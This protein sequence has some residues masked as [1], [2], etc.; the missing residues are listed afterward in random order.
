MAKN[1]LTAIG[2]EVPTNGAVATIEACQP[3][4][5]HVRIVGTAD[6]LFHR[7][8]C[9]DVKA[10]S[11]A[12]K[13]SKAKKVDNVET[14]VYRNN[15][16]DICLPG[17]YLRQSIVNAAKRLPDPCSP[18]KSARDLFVASIVSLTHLAS[19]GKKDWD[20]EHRCRVVIQRNAVTRA[21]PAFLAG[22]TADIDLLV[23]TPEY[24]SQEL[25][26]RAI[27]D[28]GRLIGVGDFRPSYGRFM[29]TRFEVGLDG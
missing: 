4:I 9:D 3:Y 20:Y 19:L 8:D 5:A 28:A 24:I 15:D 27:T 21:R 18:R 17:E 13:N 1:R 22:W 26:Q 25:L 6:L 10:K 11:E 7:W 2:G 12:G 29:V 23:Q 14:Y 16:G